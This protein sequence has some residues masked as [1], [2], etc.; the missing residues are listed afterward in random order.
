MYYIVYVSSAAKLFTEEELKEIVDISIRN[1]TSLGITGMMLYN[2]GNFIQVLEGEEE[3]VKKRYHIIERDSR[4]SGILILS[5]GKLEKRSFPDWSMGFKVIPA[6]EF[7][8]F[9]KF[10]NPKERLN[11]ADSH[12]AVTLLKSFSTL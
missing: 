2:D 3:T 6:F 7:S 4:H 12:P 10:K 1:N 11:S 5:E 8:Q 9:D